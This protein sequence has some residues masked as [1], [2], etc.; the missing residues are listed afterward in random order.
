M[1]RTVHFAVSPRLTALLGETYR[2][3]E[4]ALKELV[5]NGWDVDADNIWVTLP[6]PMTTD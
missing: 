6:K 5:D 3:T 1:T 2:L 4:A